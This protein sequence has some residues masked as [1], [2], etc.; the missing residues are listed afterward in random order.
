[1]S[2]GTS[3]SSRGRAVAETLAARPIIK[4]VRRNILET[5]VHVKVGVQRKLG[6]Y[7]HRDCHAQ[8]WSRRYRLG[9]LQT[10]TVPPLSCMRFGYDS[11]SVKDSTYCFC[12]RGALG[13][14]H[15]GRIKQVRL[16]ETGQKQDVK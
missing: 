12:R 11:S 6:F 3:V 9:C 2:S 7:T 8:D 16:A 5:G 15:E 4:T 10:A 14:L 13:R 1:M